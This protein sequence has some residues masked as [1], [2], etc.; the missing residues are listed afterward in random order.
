MI[1]KRYLVAIKR[2]A[3]MGSNATG[4]IRCRHVIKLTLSLL[5]LILMMAPGAIAR[6]MHPNAGGESGPFYKPMV[7]PNKTL[8]VHRVSNLYFAITNYGK[9]G[10]ESLDLYDPLTQLPAP[11]CEFPAESSLEYLFQGAIWIGAVVDDPE[12][13]GVLDTLV[14]IGDDGWWN[15][16]QELYPEVPPGG[17]VLM[18]SI[19]GE[20]APP[21]AP[22]HGSLSRDLPGVEFDAISEQDFICV[23][24]DTVLIGVSPDPNDNRP[25]IPLNMRI[26]Q[27]SY[28]WSYE[29]AE[30]F[31]LIDWEIENIGNVPLRNVWMGLYID[32]DVWH[33][34]GDGYEEA[35]DDLCGFLQYYYPD[36]TDSSRRTEIFT[37]Y[38]FD[39]DGDPVGT[40]AFD[41]RSPRGLSGCR[42]VRAPS[43]DTSGGAIQYGFNWWISNI[44]SQFDWG[45][46]LQAN[47]DIWGIFP[48][49]GKG[50][51][52][53][54]RAKYQVMSNDEF[55]F[56]EIWCDI[57]QPGWLPNTTQNPGDLADG[58]DTRYLYSFGE[59][60]EIPPGTV[61]PLTVGYIC[62]EKLHKD[63]ANFA[64][65]LLGGTEDS[66]AILAYYQNLDFRDF[67]TNAQWAEWVYDNPGRDSCFNK[68]TGLWEL[69]GDRGLADTASW[70]YVGTDSIPVLFWY[71]GDGCPDFKGPPPPNSPKLDFV[72]GKGY[73]ELRWQGVNPGDPNSGSEDAIDSFN[74]K[75]DFEGY[76]IYQSYDALNWTLLRRFDKVD[77]LPVLYDSTI[78]PPRWVINRDK[79]YPISTDSV[80]NLA[81]DP[82]I[83]DTTWVS[84]QDRIQ[85]H[86]Y[87]I[88]FDYNLGF[89]DIL[90]S[91]VTV[92]EVEVN[93]YSFRISGLSKSRGVYFAVTAF[94]FG[95]PLTN[96]SSLESAKSINSTLVYPIDKS[97]PIMVYPNPYRIDINYA[98][99]GYESPGDPLGWVEQDRRIW[100][101]NLPDEQQAIIR[102]WSL[103]GDLIQAIMYDPGAARGN[104]LGVAYWDLVSRNGQA[105]VSGLYL[106]S[107]E[108]ISLEDDVP[109][110]EPEIGKFAI[111]K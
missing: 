76:G 103:D 77:W 44:Q 5:M 94:D 22:T 101:A 68:D 35:Q 91:T 69:D 84:E 71:K 73:V 17:E 90:D 11:S 8:R 95:D 51:P 33:T 14:S 58:F 92:D 104:P 43:P 74:G 67:A 30:D 83:E 18:L 1:Q 6:K 97:D 66:T 109:D 2:P 89:D 111:I 59:F 57:D 56:D 12:E 41:Y 85:N 25:H 42:V 7:T 37:A 46:Q 24:S 86:T 50:T 36:A 23:Y 53:G 49:G 80:L 88:A 16:Y 107:I 99:L 52:G 75:L 40:S 60:T 93:Y 82:L 54:D 27:K 105:V 20:N 28:A 55:D 96:L 87:W 32:A 10:S 21:Y 38:I 64:N 4:R 63:P 72:A 19:R 9:L 81:D 3:R 106:Y 98:A 13:P 39:N 61:L 47:Y 65:N 78:T 110:R 34:S 79:Q 29:Y 108:F 45:P 31:V 15:P 26:I 100:F 70:E 48:G 62:G 102:I